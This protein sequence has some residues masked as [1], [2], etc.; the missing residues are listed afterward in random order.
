MSTDS[1]VVGVTPPGGT[2]TFYRVTS[3][4]CAYN[5]F[6]D[7]NGCSC[8]IYT[9]AYT[10]VYTLCQT[11]S[12]STAYF[13]TDRDTCLVKDITGEGVYLFEA[14]TW[15]DSNTGT[16]YCS[17]VYASDGTILNTEL[18]M[19]V[20][21]DANLDLTTSTST[22]ST[23]LPTASAS[24]ET[25]GSGG[26]ADWT[27]TGFTGPCICQQY[28]CYDT[29]CEDPGTM[30]YNGQVD[31]CRADGGVSHQSGGNDYGCFLVKPG[32]DIETLYCECKSPFDNTATTSSMIQT[33]TSSKSGSSP[34][35]PRGS[36]TS[37]STGPPTNSGSSDAGA[38]TTSSTTAAQT[39]SASIRFGST[40]LGSLLALLGLFYHF[41]L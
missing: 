24:T 22:S 37:S 28:L 33:H 35:T 8:I 29:G 26:S 40:K 41:T 2:E 25:S 21:H 31:Q 13:W 23:A 32:G 10:D 14:D 30:T 15:V 38:P 17:G 5:A 20:G 34:T 39:S 12:A 6:T 7:S 27:T 36:S 4:A 19:P 16:G 18:C 11:S 3:S 1:S 9:D